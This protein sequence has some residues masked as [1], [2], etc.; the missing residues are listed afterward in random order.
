MAEQVT[1]TDSDGRATKKRRADNAPSGLEAQTATT[2]RSE[3][4]RQRLAIYSKLARASSQI[5]DLDTI[6][7][8]SLIVHNVNSLG[9]WTT[10]NLVE[11]KQRYLYAFKIYSQFCKS[12]VPNSKSWPTEKITGQ[13]L[14]IPPQEQD[15]APAIF[16][17]CLFT[18]LGSGIPN[19]KTSKPG[20]DN[21][22][23]IQQATVT[24]LKS[25]LQQ[26]KGAKTLL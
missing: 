13:Y 12:I 23:K 7:P 4:S 19:T 11:L 2:S 8:Y 25:M 15:K 26:V 5:Y 24:A 10:G 20:Q 9:T 6:P 14:I 18:S 3:Y 22:D 1:S 16:Y 21:A 17:V